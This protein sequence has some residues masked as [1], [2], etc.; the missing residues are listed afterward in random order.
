VGCVRGVGAAS[1]RRPIAAAALAVTA[2]VLIAPAI[3]QSRAQGTG[4]VM[5]IRELQLKP[6]TDTAEFERFVTTTYNPG[7]EGAVPGMKGY[8][9]RADRGAQKGTYALIFIFDSANTRDRI[10]PKEGGGASEKFTAILEAPL[11]LGKELE[12]YVEPGT[13]SIYTDYVELR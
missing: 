10:F 5:A 6:G 7:W 1:L 8:I 9:A 11:T 13:L 2:L 12:R 3:A 4:E